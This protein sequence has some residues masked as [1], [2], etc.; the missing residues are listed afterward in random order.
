MES[1][2][3]FT[4]E[5]ARLLWQL[6]RDSRA[7]ETQKATLRS[8]LLARQPDGVEIELGALNIAIVASRGTSGVP[9]AV[10]W[11]SELNTRMAAHAVRAMYFGPLVP[12]LEVLGVARALAAPPQLRDDG[13]AFDARI[14][15]LKLTS[16][17]LSIGREGFVRHATPHAGMQALRAPTPSA[18]MRR[19]SPRGIRSLS[20]RLKTPTSVPP[21]VPMRGDVRSA[22][23]REAGGA[24][25][26]GT[27]GMKDQSFEMMS[28]EIS[29]T[30]PIQD[31]SALNK[32]LA[33]ATDADSA[34]AAANE[35]LRTA[36]Q[37]IEDA[38]WLAVLGIV[39]ALVKRDADGS[40]AEVHRAYLVL[41]RRL[42]SPNTLRG[43]AKLLPNKRDMRETLHAVFAKSGEGGVDALVEL[44]TEANTPGERRAYRDA[45]AACPQAAPMLGHMLGDPQWY[46]VRN[47]AAL[48]GEMGV[49]EVDG[50][51]VETLNHPDARVRRAATGALARLGTPRALHALQNMLRDA[52]PDIRRQAAL[53]LG[54]AGQRAAASDLISALDKEQD[55]DVQQ[56]LITALGKVATGEAVERLGS[57]ARAGNVF[58][59]KP[60]AVRI[61]AV[62]GLGE[63]GTPES[64]DALRTMLNERD[65]EVRAAVERAL[66]ERSA[67]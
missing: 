58:R 39:A 34:T 19:V 15:A 24:R 12:A 23:P 44:L 11:L 45:L 7:I 57:I 52:N 46:V 51:L 54:A 40:D 22:D 29:R 3:N 16:V 10:A 6:T 25:A 67:L 31:L 14:V 27:S 13:Q 1:I 38:D 26:L 55:I 49:H 61:A 37:R 59:R 5:F 63:A 65:R 9:E 8:V 21:A 20:D 47:A 50:K 30:A 2:P 41:L 4:T 36:E 43:L 17:T 48:L 42:L 66:R 33:E 62:N 60:T 28:R 56:A 35:A 32:L 53:G 64:L 18:G